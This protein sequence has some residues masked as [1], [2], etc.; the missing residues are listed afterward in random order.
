MSYRNHPLACGSFL[1]W[2]LIDKSFSKT[3]SGSIS[4]TWSLSALQ[5]SS[6]SSAV[7]QFSIA[8][9]ILSSSGTWQA[10][11]SNSDLNLK[12]TREK[13][14]NKPVINHGMHL[15]QETHV[16]VNIQLKSKQLIT[17]HLIKK[18]HVV[19]SQVHP[20]TKRFLTWQYLFF[21]NF[22]SLLEWASP[23]QRTGDSG[24]RR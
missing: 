7:C 20:T 23:S 6:W 9:P 21:Y 13:M 12:S 11:T 14:L 22:Y 24:S 18:A 5:W 1:T 3:T 8:E 15:L 2:E 10:L 19:L 17:R 4:Q 16:I